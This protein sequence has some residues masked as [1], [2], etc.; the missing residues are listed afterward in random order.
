MMQGMVEAE[1]THIF[2]PHWREIPVRTTAK[3]HNLSY[4][5]TETRLLKGVPLTLPKNM[6]WKE[7]YRYQ[8]VP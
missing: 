7:E 2:K 8:L 4:S 1:A 6:H 3:K 5:A